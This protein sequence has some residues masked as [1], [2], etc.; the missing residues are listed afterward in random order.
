MPW[1]PN[2][3]LA[4]R[5]KKDIRPVRLHLE[6]TD[7]WID[8]ERRGILKKYGES[9][10]GLSISRDI[11][12]PSDMPLHALH[13][14]IQKLFGWQNSHLHS[15]HLPDDVYREMTEGTVKGWAEMSGVLFYGIRDN[16]NDIF[17]DDDYNGGSFR[18]WLKRKYTGPY[19]YAGTGERYEDAQAANRENLLKDKNPIEVRKKYE[20]N[21][22]TGRAKGGDKIIR[23]AP[24]M[25]L[26]LEELHN[27]LIMEQDMSDLLERLE[28]PSVLAASGEALAG[29]DQIARNVSLRYDK[30]TTTLK[31]EVLPVTDKLIYRYDYGDGWEV[32]ITLLPDYRDLLET[33]RV[34]ALQLSEAEKTVKGSH[35]PVCL[36]RDGLSVMDDTGGLGGFIDFLKTINED[37]DAEERKSMREW[38]A[39]QGWSTRKI[40]DKS[41]L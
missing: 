36:Y 7:E 26:T 11:L 40:L 6:L 31:P 14:A 12:I 10:T 24:V 30:G 29:R 21:L 3:P 20:F 33:G 18:I 32:M 19:Q 28:V 23:V 1:I 5:Q 17:W 2:D 37:E 41:V 38:A 27:S 22:K 16:Q 15:F 9:S 13:Y 8:E 39:G 35:K 34:T 4:D 25:E